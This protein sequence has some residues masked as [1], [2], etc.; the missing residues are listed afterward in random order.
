MQYNIKCNHLSLANK[1]YK[2]CV[3]SK[4]THKTASEKLVAS[5]I[6][7]LNGYRSISI[8][9]VMANFHLESISIELVDKIGIG[10]SLIKCTEISWISAVVGKAIRS[11]YIP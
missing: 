10:G 11:E 4:L 6:L 7:C 3:I 1:Q 9:Q 2:K 5:C 8:G